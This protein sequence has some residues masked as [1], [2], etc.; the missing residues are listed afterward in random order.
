MNLGTQGVDAAR[1]I[2]EYCNFRSGSYWSDLRIQHG[3]KEPHSIKVWCLGNEMDGAWQIGHKTASEYG[4]IAV[5]AAKV[6]KWTDPSIEL[7]ACG[8]SSASMSTFGDWEQTVLEHTYD[9][10]DYISLHT[11]LGNRHNDTAD[12]LAMT[13]GV[14]DFIK[15]V[16]SICDFIKGKKRAKKTLNLSFDEW[17]VWFHSHEQ[18]K[19]MEP[20]SVAPPLLE[21]VYTFEDALVVG[22]FI[23]TLLK[24]ADRIKMACLAQLV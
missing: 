21:D 20:W 5:E 17:N 4:R 9:Y 8:S 15:T 19:T 22:S 18:D 12:F 16:I 14:D 24:H 10:V 2:V 7:V 3:Y 11:Y 6:M 23:I 1:N 13:V